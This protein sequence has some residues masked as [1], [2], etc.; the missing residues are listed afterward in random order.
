MNWLK[1]K[2]QK[3]KKFQANMNDDLKLTEGKK[4]Y[5]I[6]GFSIVEGIFVST[7]NQ[8]NYIKQLD[9]SVIGYSTKTSFP[10]KELALEK[11]VEQL[12][13]EIWQ[14][15]KNIKEKL[16]LPSI[17]KFNELIQATEEINKT[18]KKQK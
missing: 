6:S 17:E 1:K 9:G 12:K 13:N 7:N 16:D 18:I 8:W 3:R 15:L 2:S 14:S 4:A 10:T 11:L 5:V